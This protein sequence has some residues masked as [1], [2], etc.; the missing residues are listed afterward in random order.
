MA[1][2]QYINRIERPPVAG[3]RLRWSLMLIVLLAGIAAS[4]WLKRAVVLQ[5][6]ADL[7]VVSDPI[8]RADA[9]VV[10]GGGADL[11]PFVAADLYAKGIVHKVLVSQVQVGPPAKLGVVLEHTE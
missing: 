6:A 11:R 5:G 8:T 4:V 10:L 2:S 7:W 1:S 9:A 3:R